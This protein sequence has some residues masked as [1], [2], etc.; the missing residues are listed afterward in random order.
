MQDSVLVGRYRSV[1]ERAGKGTTEN[2][3]MAQG[4]A[5]QCRTVWTVQDSVERC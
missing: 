4:S 5:G 3:R 1:Q 2:S